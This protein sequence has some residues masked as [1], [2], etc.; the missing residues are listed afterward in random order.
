V[1]E[2][3]ADEF[4]EAI[5]AWGELRGDGD[6]WGR[7]AE[8]QARGLKWFLESSLR[9]AVHR[10]LG[11]G[12]YERSDGRRGH[13]NGF[14]VRRL[15]TKYGSVEIMVPR[16]R[17]GSYEHGLW[18][19]NGL[20][21]QEAR[22]LILETYLSGPSTRRMGEVLERVLGYEVSAATVSAICKGL[23]DLVRAYWREQ[24]GDDWE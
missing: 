24:I 4:E 1:R 19:S 9:E 16:L 3:Y 2:L 13:R 15:V 20:L 8:F 10:K 18:E 14:Y 12:W 7:Y 5:A 23:D 17:E 6:I 22:D 11:V 21:T